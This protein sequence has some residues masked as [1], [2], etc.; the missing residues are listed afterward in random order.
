MI[1]KIWMDIYCEP[2]VLQDLLDQLAKMREALELIAN[3]GNS[4]ARDVL[5][6]IKIPQ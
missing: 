2:S 3:K 1:E 5:K 6:K 4:V